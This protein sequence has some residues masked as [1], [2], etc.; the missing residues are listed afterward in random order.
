MNHFHLRFFYFDSVSTI[1][2]FAQTEVFFN[3]E[4]F[5][6][7]FPDK[8]DGSM[9][10]AGQAAPPPDEQPS[11]KPSTSGER[12]QQSTAKEPNI[13]Q[14]MQQ[15]TVNEPVPPSQPKRQQQQ[16]KQKQQQPQQQ[17]QQSSP[18]SGGG[19]SVRQFLQQVANEQM[20]GSQPTKQQQ[21]Q[22]TQQQ[23]KQK[24]H[25][26]N[27]KQQQPESS[28]LGE[29]SGSVRQFL[30]QVANEQMSGSQP[31][32]KQQQPQ[33]Q[34]QQKQQKQQQQSSSGGQGQQPKAKEPNVHQFPA[35]KPMG[36]SQPQKQVKQQQ[37]LPA[38]PQPWQ[39]PQPQQMAWGP[40]QGKQ[41]QHAWPEQPKGG[42]PKTGPPP[43]FEVERNRTQG[44]SQ[45]Q[46]SMPIDQ[47]PRSVP[48]A[49]ST[50]SISSVSSSSTSTSG[51][52]CGAI[53]KASK[54]DKSIA[55][56]GMSLPK[57]L[58]AFRPITKAPGTLGRKLG[59]IE[60]N[61]LQ[62]DI[63]KLVDNVYKYDVEIEIEKGPKN[64]FNLAAFIEFCRI[65][66]PNQRGISYDWRKIVL[67]ARPL[68]IKGEL[69]GEV[70]I[71]HPH[72]GKALNY[73][74][75][76][77]PAKDGAMVPVKHALAK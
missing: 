38:P 22:Q 54:P 64:K 6:G 20:S 58:R 4:F 8:K 48:R 5:L 77:K 42:K 13:R 29:R 60:T 49:G 67:T 2:C 56:K 25:K 28:S 27:Q 51:A 26:Q 11:A 24:Q 18:L 40:S 7:I 16:Q 32:K 66:M 21:Q 73:T 65:H 43:S 41:Q 69:A 72:T 57:D 70:Q 36:G 62:L 15:L 52:H 71:T 61:F 39:Q 33:P 3:F 76:I 23:H 75:T 9:K 46:S 30:Q 31:T 68:N 34:Q 50:Q 74:V 44:P 35:N 53:P 19:G 10:P 47:L 12:S 14:S 59:F 17:Q 1:F 45:H 63:S 37:P 55:E